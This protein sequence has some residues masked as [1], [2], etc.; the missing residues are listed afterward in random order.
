V[1]IVV[2][3]ALYAL[4]G[5]AIYRGQI[6]NQRMKYALSDFVPRR[7]ASPTPSPPAPTRLG[8]VT[9][10]TEISQIS[11][12]LRDPVL[13]RSAESITL[14]EGRSSFASETRPAGHAPAGVAAAAA[15]ADPY[16]AP[17]FDT[18][19]TRVAAAPC[20]V[21]LGAHTKITTTV[22]AH[23]CGALGPSLYRRA[24]SQT[25]RGARTYALVAFSLYVVMLVTWV[26]ST[27]NRVYGVLHADALNFG[28]NALASTVLPLQGFFNTCVYMFISRGELWRKFQELRGRGKR[29]HGGGDRDEPR[30]GSIVEI[31]R[32]ERASRESRASMIM[33][34][35]SP[36]V[37][38]DVD[39][40]EEVVEK[41]HLPLH[42]LPLRGLTGSD[43]FKD[44]VSEFV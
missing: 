39:G 25:N 29:P 35:A 28:L 9:K 12:V 23:P 13:K 36:P 19:T 41:G 17:S 38:K 27:A 32:A 20:T 24:E 4:A 18:T 40:V 16:R 33:R 42:H 7:G 10:R 43:L 37:G 26:P 22:E 1:T 30:K 6:K 8:S 31:A 44:A 5:R 34:A 15:A 3:M 2:T 11:E 14:A 21:D